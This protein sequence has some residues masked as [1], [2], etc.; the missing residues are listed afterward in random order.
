MSPFAP[1][2]FLHVRLYSFDKG[3]GKNLEMLGS[4]LSSQ[5]HFVLGHYFE[6]NLTDD[7]IDQFLRPADILMIGMSSKSP[8]VELA[9]THKAQE[10]KIPVIWFSDTH[11]VFCRP[12]FVNSGLWP[13]SVTVLDQY[14]ADLAMKI[15]YPRAVATGLPLW[16]EIPRMT[17][18]V[19]QVRRKLGVGQ[20]RLILGV[21]GK[22]PNINVRILNDLF[23]ALGDYTALQAINDEDLICFLPRFHPGDPCHPS[24]NP[25]FYESVL[26]GVPDWV[27]EMIRNDGDVWGST[28]QLVLAS[29][30]VFASHSGA[31]MA[32]VFHRKAVIDYLPDYVMER[33]AKLTGV[34]IWPPAEVGATLKVTHPSHL[35]IAIDFAL[36]DFGHEYIRSAQERNYP[37][38]ESGMALKKLTA[39]VAYQTS[40]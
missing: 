37:I 39:E 23:D 30:L 5:G 34:S 32:A 8:G 38:P 17:L 25:G 12:A 22:D 19:N 33:L 29:D 1:R 10:R 28:D 27:I 2:K 9:L 21:F 3:P 6:K 16:E 40:T 31:G 14:E 11:L 7:Y 13:N 15:G 35:G 24:N 36:S 4:Y 26:E 18:D 20:K